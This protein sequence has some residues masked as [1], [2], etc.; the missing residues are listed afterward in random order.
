[1]ALGLKRTC[2][3]I[4]IIRDSF[5]SFSDP[6]LIQLS[7]ITVLKV[8]KVLQCEI[9]FKVFFKHYCALKYDFLLPKAF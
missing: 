2:R 7:R 3:A 6:Y 8:Y 1:M 4:Q 9:Y 5:L